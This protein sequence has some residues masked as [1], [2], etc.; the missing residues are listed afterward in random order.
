MMDGVLHI[1]RIHQRNSIRDVG[2]DVHQRIVGL[3][4]PS[5]VL[6]CDGARFRDVARHQVIG[7]Q[8]PDDRSELRLKA[9]LLGEHSCARHCDKNIRCCVTLSR[10]ETRADN[11]LKS[12]LAPLAILTFLHLREKRKTSPRKH[13]RFLVRKD[14]C[15]G[16]CCDTEIMARSISIACRLEEESKLCRERPCR[17]LLHLENCLSDRPAELNATRH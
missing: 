9:K 13:R 12:E 2:A 5:Y 1:A 4:C 10:S 6:V 7:E 8:S 15:S 17:S 16:T 11:A 14:F 3:I